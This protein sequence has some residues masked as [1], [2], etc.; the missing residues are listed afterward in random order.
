MKLFK[1]QILILVAILLVVSINSYKV[2]SRSKVE[3]NVNNQFKNGTAA[4]GGNASAGNATVLIGKPGSDVVGAKNLQSR[5]D[6]NPYT[7]SRCDQIV[8]FAAKTIDDMTNYAA[9]TPRF[10][11]MNM[12]S[13]V[14]FKSKDVNTFER[15]LN[16][17]ALTNVPNIIQGSISCIL[18]KTYDREI[19]VCMPTLAE[20]DLVLDAYKQFMKCRAG[21]DLLKKKESPQDKLQNMLNIGCLGLTVS[22]DQG[23]MESNPA[24]AE[25]A[26]NASINAILLKMVKVKDT[27]LIDTSVKGA[28]DTKVEGKAKGVA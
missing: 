5:I 23:E 17:A 2:K 13:V 27:F 8:E 6:V 7:V 15:L 4:A 26:L 16:V 19:N 11:T 3:L 10:F 18:F 21:N 24:Q 14:Q 22:F 20:A 12:Y 25:A 9:Q 28:T 1:N